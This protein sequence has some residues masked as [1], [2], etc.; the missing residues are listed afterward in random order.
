M[1]RLAQR[2]VGDTLT[3]IQRVRVRPDA[4][5]QPRPLADS[6]LAT[7]ISPPSLTRE[8]DTVRIAYHIAVWQAGTNE[9]TLPGAVVVSAGGVVDTLP[10][11]HVLLQVASVLPNGKPAASLAPKRPES[12]VPRGD[13]SPI[14]FVVLLGLVLI[15][16]LLGRWWQR[17]RGPRRPAVAPTPSPVV[18]G[19]Q[20]ERWIAAGEAQLAL[21]H[22]EALLGAR[23]DLAEWR[24]RAAAARYSRE[25]DAELA[26]LVREGW[27][28]RG[29]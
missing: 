17:R 24:E 5:V 6:T 9:L 7:L 29:A 1:Q 27:E 25:S 21:A 14:P 10:D 22:V 23:P 28:A 18:D 2:T 19:E 20:I 8:G 3:I 15:G 4:V 16:A 11:G 12:V 13:R 26:V